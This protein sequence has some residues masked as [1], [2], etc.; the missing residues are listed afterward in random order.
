MTCDKWDYDEYDFEDDA[1]DVDDEY[2]GDMTN[3]FPLVEKFTLRNLPREIP[4]WAGVIM[5]NSCRKDEGR[6]G[7]RQCA[8]FECGKWEEYPRQFAKCRRCKRTKYCSKECQLAAWMYHRHW[9]IQSTSS[10]SSS[11][12]SNRTISTATTSQTQS[13]AGTALSDMAM[14]RVAEAPGPSAGTTTTDQATA[15][16]TATTNYNIHA[17]HHHQ[18][19]HHR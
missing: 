9:C 8:N 17:P 12:V 15:A 6:G 10:S 13:Q 5:R 3:I 1:I 19:H 2:L 4:Y 16:A 11:T 18:H 7:I 14:Q